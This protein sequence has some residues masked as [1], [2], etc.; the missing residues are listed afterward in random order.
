MWCYFVVNVPEPWLCQPSP[1]L[2]RVLSFETLI[3]YVPPSMRPHDLEEDRLLLKVT[4][5]IIVKVQTT[6]WLNRLSRDTSIVA[7]QRCRDELH[8]FPSHV[9]SSSRGPSA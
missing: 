6:A 1:S 5:G 2:S 7:G 4:S 8:E 3:Q 9:S